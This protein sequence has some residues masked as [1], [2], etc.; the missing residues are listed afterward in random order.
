MGSRC[1]ATLRIINPF[2]TDYPPVDNRLSLTSFTTLSLRLLHSL[3][4][5]SRLTLAFDKTPATTMSH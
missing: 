3:T 2:T 5:Q 4:L 1:T